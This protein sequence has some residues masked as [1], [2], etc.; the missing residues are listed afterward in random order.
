MVLRVVFL[1]V[2]ALAAGLGIAGVVAAATGSVG[3]P[4]ATQ[5]FQ[6][7]TSARTCV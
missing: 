2:V 5:A 3:P 7:P 4:A 1:V 6:P